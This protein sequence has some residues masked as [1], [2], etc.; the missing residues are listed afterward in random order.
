MSPDSTAWTRQAVV[1]Y[2]LVLVLVQSVTW[3]TLGMQRCMSHSGG[4]GEL[5][6]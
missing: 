2:I 6:V 4:P 5:K 3:K 1:Q